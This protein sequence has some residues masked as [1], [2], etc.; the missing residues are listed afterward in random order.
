MYYP[1]SYEYE[2]WHYEK[3]NIDTIRK[4]IDDFEQEKHFANSSVNEKIT[5][6]NQ[7]GKKIISNYIPH[8]IQI[9]AFRDPPWL[10]NQAKE[11][12]ENENKVC[13]N[14]VQSNRSDYL[15]QKFQSNQ[16]YLSILIE[17]LTKK[18]IIPTGQVNLGIEKPV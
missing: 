17:N 8:G 12:L 13:K 5:F 4:A 15:F 11:L 18:S 16:N 3:A 9:F 2:A 14:Y 6:F 10:N 7:T 1:P